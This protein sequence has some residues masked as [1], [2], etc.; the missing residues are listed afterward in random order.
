MRKEDCFYLGHVSRKHALK[1]E[2]IAVFDTDQK[3][4]YRNLESVFMLVRDELI[5]FF[6]EESAQNSKGHFIL[7][8]EDIDTAE[9]AD[10]LI[11]RELYLP[12]N[13][14]PQLSGKAFYFHE[15]MDFSV[16]DAIEGNIGKCVGVNDHSAQPIFQIQDGDKTILVP[17]VDDFIVS[18]DREAKQINLDCPPGLID[19]YR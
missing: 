6:I 14:L 5:P 11:G 9:K 13:V 2:I 17:A 1:G 10:K 3:E 4:N 7:H 8:F 15:V 16:M 12:L 19:I 18:I